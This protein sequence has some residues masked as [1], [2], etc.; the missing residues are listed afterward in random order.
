[1]QLDVKFD[2]KIELKEFYAL[3]DINYSISDAKQEDDSLEGNVIVSGNYYKS[4][5]EEKNTFSK[6]IPFTVVFKNNDYHYSAVEVKNFTY[7]EIVN[8]GIECSFELQVEYDI[9]SDI[10]DYQEDLK[11]EIQEKYDDLLNEILKTRDDNFLDDNIS[12]IEAK[13]ELRV[14][15]SKLKESSTSYRVYYPNSDKQ[16]EQI[17]ALEKV[18]IDK[19]YKSNSDYAKTK[20]VVVK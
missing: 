10:E 18:G 15:L 14:D 7:S 8:F 19:L 11:S 13:D 17:A 1:M 2:D 5:M 4:D 20:R 16:L 6:A 3:T 9:N 12:V